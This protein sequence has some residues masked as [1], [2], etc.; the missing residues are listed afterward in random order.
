MHRGS[1]LLKRSTGRHCQIRSCNGNRSF[2]RVHTKVNA[3]WVRGKWKCEKE[4][5]R[6]VRSYYLMSLGALDRQTVP[7]SWPPLS[8]IYIF[9]RRAFCLRQGPLFIF[10]HFLFSFLSFS[11]RSLINSLICSGTHAACQTQHTDNSRQN[12]QTDREARTRQANA[13]RGGTKTARNSLITMRQEDIITDSGNEWTR[14]QS[15]ATRLFIEHPLNYWGKAD[16]WQSQPTH[17]CHCQPW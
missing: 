6:L 2:R 10:G 5:A 11:F 4:S 8:A 7:V 3:N 16:N 14:T 17:Q 12:T 13:L 9:P 1:E 15:A